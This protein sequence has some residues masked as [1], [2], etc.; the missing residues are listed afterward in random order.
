MLGVTDSATFGNSLDVQSGKFLVD[1]SGNSTFGGTLGVAGNSTLSGTLG[2]TGASTF[3]NSVNVQSGKFVIDSTGNVGF[4]STPSGAVVDIYNNSSRIR[5]RGTGT[6]L[7]WN[8]TGSSVLSSVI[9]DTDGKVKMYSS[10]A[11]NPKM[12]LDSNTISIIG[13]PTS[14]TLTTTKHTAIT[15]VGILTVSGLYTVS[16][17]QTGTTATLSG[18]DATALTAYVASNKCYLYVDDPNYRTKI[19]FPTI[20]GSNVTFVDILTGSAVS[21]TVSAENKKVYVATAVVT[22]SG[23]YLSANLVTAGNPQVVVANQYGKL[24]LSA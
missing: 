21:G 6:G 14:A 4:G 9:Y 5:M 22:N 13:D 24:G 23:D 16:V 7:E 3:G 11:T 12:S 2:V 17:S 15:P 8:N 18:T 19:L 1:A 10:S 20:S